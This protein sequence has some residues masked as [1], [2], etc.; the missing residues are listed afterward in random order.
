LNIIRTR[1]ELRKELKEALLPE[2]DAM[3]GN[4]G[5]WRVALACLGQVKLWIW[6]MNLSGHGI[7]CQEN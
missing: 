1:P 7:N 6:P 3:F 4:R 2:L 5:R